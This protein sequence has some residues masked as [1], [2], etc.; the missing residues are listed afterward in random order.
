MAN[1]DSEHLAES[2][3]LIIREA[4]IEGKDVDVPGLGLFRINRRPSEMEEDEDG[5]IVMRPPR[6]EVE[7]VPTA[8]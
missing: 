2:I 5:Q 8:D 3:G 4:L 7:F 1:L 6:D